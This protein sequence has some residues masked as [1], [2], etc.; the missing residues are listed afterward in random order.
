MKIKIVI[1]DKIV[2]VEHSIFSHAITCHSLNLRQWATDEREKYKK[3]LDQEP[4]RE[5]AE[6]NLRWLYD[7]LEKIAE[8]RK[9]NDELHTT[10]DEVIQ[11]RNTESFLSQ[12]KP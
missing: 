9:A 5:N 10:L 12:A 2:E 8:H 1:G 3:F 4:D 11:R 7:E 6:R